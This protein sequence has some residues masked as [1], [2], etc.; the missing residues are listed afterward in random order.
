MIGLVGG[1]AVVHVPGGGRR[2]LRGVGKAVALVPHLVERPGR[3]HG[4]DRE[5]RPFLRNLGAV[6]LLVGDVL[7]AQRLELADVGLVEPVGSGL[8]HRDREGV[9]VHV[10]LAASVVAG[11]AGEDVTRLLVDDGGAVPAEVVDRGGLEELVRHQVVARHLGVGRVP[12]HPVGRPAEGQPA[13]VGRRAASARHARPRQVDERLV[14]VRHVL[15]RLDRARRM[16]DGFERAVGAH[17]RRRE[18]LRVQRAGTSRELAGAQ[19]GQR[20]LVRHVDVA[21]HVV[22]EQVAVAAAARRAD[23]VPARHPLHRIGLP[24]VVGVPEEARLGRRPGR[25]R[26]PGV[27]VVVDGDDRLAHAADRVDDRGH[28]HA[29]GRGRPRRLRRG[30]GRQ[31]ERDHCAERSHPRPPQTPTTHAQPS[32]RTAE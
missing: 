12:V 7:Q 19:A 32:T 16:E 28:A 21:V 25:R 20:L 15:G 6:G 17:G 31:P 2:R 14:A 8:A 24:A 1:I 4:G 29:E 26:D 30:H 9:V 5:Q 10:L 27:V 23:P 3:V 13:R 11:D 22:D 18:A